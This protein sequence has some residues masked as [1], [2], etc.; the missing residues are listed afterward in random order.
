MAEDEGRAH[1]DELL[2]A[3]QERLA[4]QSEKLIAAEEQGRELERQVALDAERSR[5]SRRQVRQHK[6]AEQMREL[7]TPKH[8]A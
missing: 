4:G 5:R 1:I 3:T 6:M 2:T 7:Q 8:E